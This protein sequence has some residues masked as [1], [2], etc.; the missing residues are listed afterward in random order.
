VN[1]LINTQPQ[2]LSN[3]RDNIGN[4]IEMAD[5]LMEYIDASKKPPME[6]R[7]NKH[8]LVEH[9]LFL[10]AANGLSVM[11]EKTERVEIDGVKGF[12]ARTV[13]LRDGHTV[14]AGDAWCMENE[15]NWKGRDLYALASMA[16]TRSISKALSSQLRWIVTM[17]GADW[18]PTPA[19]EMIGIFDDDDIE[20]DFST[21]QEAV[22]SNVESPPEI[23]TPAPVENPKMQEIIRNFTAEIEQ[24]EEVVTPEE[25]FQKLHEAPEIPQGEAKVF[26]H[27]ER[28]TELVDAATQNGV[29]ERVIFA[30]LKDPNSKYPPKKGLGDYVNGAL[31]I[32]NKGGKTG[33]VWFDLKKLASVYGQEEWFPTS[34]EWINK[35]D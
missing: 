6:I 9:W 7:G 21:E 30:H 8:L 22:V 15:R 28:I 34:L 31:G 13:V 1:E 18:S 3:P 25:Q 24:E 5:A 29:D 2:S 14:G 33:W 12:H 16:Q 17:A 35:L 4:A 10:A 23:S 27:L 11:N 32:H 19:E 20:V 26:K